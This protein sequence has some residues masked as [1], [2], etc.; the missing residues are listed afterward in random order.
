MR[1]SRYFPGA[2]VIAID[3]LVSLTRELDFL[4]NRKFSTSKPD[5]FSTSRRI[6]ESQQLNVFF[7]TLTKGNF[8]NIFNMLALLERCHKQ[9]KS[10][11]LV[12]LVSPF[13][14]SD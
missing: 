4:K 6:L 1:V 12:Y 9:R 11:V 13:P 10:L 5:V 7:S 8:E 14:W 3:F 2:S